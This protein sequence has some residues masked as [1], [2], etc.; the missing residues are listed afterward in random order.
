MPVPTYLASQTFETILARILANAPAGED[1]NEG[2]FLS[3]AARLAAAEFAEAN[4]R[5]Q[6]LLEYGFPLTD[7]TVPVDDADLRQY[8]ILRG[9]EHDLTP[10]EAVAATGAVAVTAP[11]G[12]VVDVGE[13]FSTLG[14]TSVPSITFRA[15][16]QVVVGVSGTAL[17]PVEAVVPG[18]AG[19]VLAGSI[20]VGGGGVGVTAVTNPSALTGGVDAESNAAFRERILFRIQHPSASGNVADYQTWATE[21]AGVGGATVVPV[22]SGPGTVDVYVIG[23]DG[24]PVDQTVIDRAQLYIAPPY[25]QLFQAE[26]FA[27]TSAFGVS[28]VDRS[29]DTGTTVQMVY[30]AGGVGRV[31]QQ[32]METVLPTTNAGAANA[33]IWQL[34]PKVRVDSIVG[35]ANL[36]ELGVWNLTT[37]AWCKRSPSSL[38]DAKYTWS[39]SDLAT[40]F[41]HLMADF[42][43]NGVDEIEIRHTRLQADVTTTLQIDEC[44]VTSTFSQD[45]GDGG[46]APVGARVSVDTVVAVPIDVA[47]SLI[48]ETGYDTASVRDAV[49]D[50]VKA[51]LAGLALAEDRDVR[52]AR[53]ANAILDTP[54]VRDFSDLT[55]NGGTANIAIAPWE[56]A[57]WGV[58]AM[59]TF[60]DLDAAGLDFD[61][62]D[63]LEETFD[64]LNL[65]PG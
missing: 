60:D 35:V 12:T 2:S 58:P 43:W 54:G 7:E 49:E 47:V 20:Q 39:A 65:E 57:T 22:G 14:T 62:Y 13:V 38:V 16:E 61:Q 44:L 36:Y 59:V 1:L 28:T 33:G 6:V 5:A 40:A 50:S 41:T 27:V 32:D 56:V 37:A 15:T 10:K 29:D 4:V 25:T 11:D 52:W 8:L 19:N 30:N 63:A 64:T 45:S 24:L 21:V 9:Q 51:Y 46:K 31:T 55:L 42:Y 3:D 17:V 26:D 48:Y 34:R 18:A 23:P 53:V